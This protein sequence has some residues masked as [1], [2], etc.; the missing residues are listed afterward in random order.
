MVQERDREIVAGKLALYILR[1][2]PE[3]SIVPRAGEAGALQ[4][5]ERYQIV[6]SQR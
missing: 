5:V 3:I 4:L 1:Y 2:L 6:A